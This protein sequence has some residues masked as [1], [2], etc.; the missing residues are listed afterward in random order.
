MRSPESHP[1]FGAAEAV[2]T[3]TNLEY[4]RGRGIG[5]GIARAPGGK[6]ARLPSTWVGASAGPFPK[7]SHVGR[8]EYSESGAVAAA[9]RGGPGN[10]PGVLAKGRLGGRSAWSKPLLYV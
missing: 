1:Q 8:L 10:V 4:S 5:S 9:R 2:N 7:P 6:A 3:A